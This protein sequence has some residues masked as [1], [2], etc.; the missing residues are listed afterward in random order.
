[1]LHVLGVLILASLGPNCFYVSHAW[2]WLG[3]K[4]HSPLPTLDTDTEIL[5][6]DLGISKPE[7]SSF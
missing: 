3:T 6:H 1:M 7:Q 5:D 2:A 4:K